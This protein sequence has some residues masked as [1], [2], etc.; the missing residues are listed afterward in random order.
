MTNTKEY[1]AMTETIRHTVQARE[2]HALNVE[3]TNSDFSPAEK[4]ALQQKISG[5]FSALNA[6]AAP[7]AH[8]HGRFTLLPRAGASTIRN[9]QPA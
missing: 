2:L 5:R 7:A 1:I 6:A 9:P 3:I 8:P 4:T